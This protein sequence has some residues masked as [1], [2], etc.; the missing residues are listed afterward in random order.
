MLRDAIFYLGEFSV[1][2]KGWGL[3]GCTGMVVY[4]GGLAREGGKRSG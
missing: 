4:L 1:G 3:G 2:D